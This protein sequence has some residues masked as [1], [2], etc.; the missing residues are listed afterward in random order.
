MLQLVKILNTNFEKY[1]KKKL[2]PFEQE[3]LAEL[4]TNLQAVRVFHSKMMEHMKV[5]RNISYC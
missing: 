2:D 3:K 1:S 4:K 5:G